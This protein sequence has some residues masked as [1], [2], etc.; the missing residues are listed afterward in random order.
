MMPLALDF[1]LSVHYVGGENPSGKD[2]AAE[3]QPVK[4]AELE[5]RLKR[6]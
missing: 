3:E 4:A 2:I 1:D 6:S 5:Q